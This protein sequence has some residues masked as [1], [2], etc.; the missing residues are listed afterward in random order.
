MSGLGVPQCPPP[1]PPPVPDATLGPNAAQQIANEF[2]ILRDRIQTLENLFSNAAGELT[3]TRDRAKAAVDQVAAQGAKILEL[4]RQLQEQRQKIREDLLKA[5]VVDTRLLS[6]PKDFGGQDSHW[7]DWSFIF[8]A[9]VGAISETFLSEV[10]ADANPEETIYNELPTEE[11]RKISMQLY[12]L[13]ALLCKVKALDVVKEVP[14]GAGLECWRKLMRKYEPRIRN[15]FGRMLQKVLNWKFTAQD[16]TAHLAQWET[17]VRTYETQSKEKL[18]DAIKSGVV[19]GNLEDG[20]L[21]EHLQLD[22]EKME[23]F[24]KLVTTIADYEATK[25]SWAP[26]SMDVSAVDNTERKGR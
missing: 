1:D 14:R 19:V 21:K 15:R 11:S 6:K 17:D 24:T 4:E 16:V 9:Y 20:P 22:S 10:Q 23:N 18:S 2:A 3:L 26:D 13:L 12:F 25:K 7:K 5:G 8:E